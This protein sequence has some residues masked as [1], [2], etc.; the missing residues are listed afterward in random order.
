VEGGT[1]LAEIAISVDQVLYGA[2]Q[3]MDGRGG[4]AG[5]TSRKS[6]G[7]DA[8]RESGAGRADWRSTCG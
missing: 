1:T 3:L 6:I 8:P 4:N 2:F 7:S 5:V